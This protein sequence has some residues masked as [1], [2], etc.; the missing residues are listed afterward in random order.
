MALPDGGFHDVRSVRAYLFINVPIGILT[1]LLGSR[2]LP[3][4]DP[5]PTQKLDVLGLLLL[6]PGL[7]ALIYG[8]AHVPAHE[9]FAYPEVYLPAGA[10]ALLVIAFLW[11]AARAKQPL[12]DLNLFR[13]RGVWMAAVTMALFIIAFFGTLLLFPLY[14]QQVRGEDALHAGLLIAPQGIGVM[15][16]MSFAGRLVDRGYAARL[17][18]LG[19]AVIVAST[20][21][22][23]RLTAT[24]PYWTIGLALF[25]VGLG[26]GMVGM[27]NMSIALKALRPQDIARASTSLSIIQQV[28][29]SIGTA[30][31]SVILFNEVKDRIAPV[32]AQLQPQP[33]GSGSPVAAPLQE[34]PE[35]IRPLLAPVLADAYASTF[36]WALL[37]LV[38]SLV[39]ALLRL[40]YKTAPAAPDGPGAVDTHAPVHSVGGHRE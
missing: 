11:H 21:L 31:L 37:L 23:T 25:A 18:A 17:V 34:L 3:G 33:P 5:R 1:L 7:A 22:F 24:T 32:L 12:I 13:N 10:G 35:Q 28:S 8:L 16:M 29:A 36:G 38:S 40:R 4:D 20:A 26:M 14:F 19:I 15:V 27:P 9:G 39:P 6:S 30:M 2:V